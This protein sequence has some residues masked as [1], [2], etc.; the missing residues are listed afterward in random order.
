MLSAGRKGCL[1]IVVFE[2]NFGAH[3]FS[4]VFRSERVDVDCR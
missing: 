1:R 4:A 3:H 2:I